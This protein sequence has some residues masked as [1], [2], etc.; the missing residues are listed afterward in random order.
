LKEDT[1]VLDHDDD[2]FQCGQNYGAH[3]VCR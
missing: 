1:L 2:F 3:A